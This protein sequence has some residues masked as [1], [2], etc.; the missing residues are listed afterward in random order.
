[1]T[2]QKRDQWSSNFGF[3]MAATGSAIGLGNLWKFPYLAGRNGGALFLLLYLF[4]LILL[5]VP[6]LMSEM[7]LGRSTR[8]N[9]IDAYAATSP[10]WRFAGQLGVLC[11]FLILSYYSVVGRLG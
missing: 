4:F 7:A 8:K 10:K 2:G 5:G 3:I 6:I 1:M 9:A 11:A